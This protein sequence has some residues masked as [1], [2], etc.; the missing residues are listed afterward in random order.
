MKAMRAVLF[1]S[2]CLIL[3]TSST[4]ARGVCDVEMISFSSASL[5]RFLLSSDEHDHTVFY[6]INQKGFFG[7][8]KMTLYKIENSANTPILLQ[9]RIGACTSIFAHEGFLYYVLFDS[10]THSGRLFRCSFDGKRNEPVLDEYGI[11]EILGV[12]N[13]CLYFETHSN[14]SCLDL[15]DRSISVIAEKHLYLSHAT[16]KGI[17]LYHAK[18]WKFYPWERLT[19]P[20]VITY[21][22]EKS[23]LST[24]LVAYSPQHYW[25]YDQESLELCVFNPFS[26]VTLQG[27]QSVSSSKGEVVALMSGSSGM[28]LYTLD[29]YDEALSAAA[30]S[31]TD[32][33][34]S[35]VYIMNQ[36]VFYIDEHD[37]LR[38][39]NIRGSARK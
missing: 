22:S 39:I 30:I 20:E 23:V 13:G 10:Y 31:L 38:T 8:E 9:S 5:R 33:I 1:I 24:R 35:C 28:V 11:G 19:Q 16:E 26:S 15:D 34:D 36:T 18:Q 7:I 32:S 25:I 27:V 14:I 21:E 29:L 4:Q 12:V 3:M 17:G 6:A 2:L 37:M